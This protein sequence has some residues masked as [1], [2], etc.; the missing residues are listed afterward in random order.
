MW[1]HIWVLDNYVVLAILHEDEMIRY[2]IE[3]D[4]IKNDPVQYCGSVSFF[5]KS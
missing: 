4:Y 2:A 1:N 5:Y 3:A